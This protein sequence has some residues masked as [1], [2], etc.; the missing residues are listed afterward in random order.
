MPSPKPQC[1]NVKSKKFH[2]ERCPY[3]AKRGDFCSR[4][5]KNPQMYE[6]PKATRSITSMVR[7]IQKFWRT[8]Y[9]RFLANERGP[10]FFVRSLCNNE[11]ELAS[12][13]PVDQIEKD[14]FFSIQEGPLVWGFDIRALVVQYEANGTLENP[15]TKGIYPVN[16]VQRFKRHLD[17]LKRWKKKIHYE[18]VSGLTQKQSWNLRVLDMCLRLDILGYRIATHWFTELDIVQ[19]KR[20][21]SVMFTTWNNLSEINRNQIVPGPEN[22]FKWTPDCI[23]NKNDLDSVRRT[24]LNVIERLISSATEQSDRTLGAMHSVMSLTKVSYRCRA[25][26]PWLA[27]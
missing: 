9:S 14:Y 5:Y 8:R 24:N 6:F 1:M 17:T 25:A 4:H 21:Y 18:E 12:F 13:E 15:Y 3:P 22:L 27:A 20:L 7:R 2:K 16:I 10:G 23:L 19:Q 11:T 26:Y